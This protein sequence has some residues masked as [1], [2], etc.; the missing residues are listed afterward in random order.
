VIV[1]DIAKLNS[2]GYSGFPAISANSVATNDAFVDQWNDAL[3]RLVA[4]FDTMVQVAYCDDA[5]NK[6]AALLW[7]VDGVH[8]NEFGSAHIAEAIA[9]A[10]RRL[11]PPPGPRFATSAYVNSPSPRGGQVIR[12][13]RPATWYTAEYSQIGTAYTFVAGDVFAMPF[14]VTNP[15][16]R[17]RQFSMEITTAS[18]TTAATIRWGLYDDPGASGY[19]FGLMHELTSGGT[20][21]V[22]TTTG[23]KT[24]PLPAAA[25]S[26]DK[27]LDPGVYWLCFKV[28]TIGSAT[29]ACRTLGGK[30]LLMPNAQQ[31]GLPL[32]TTGGY[33]GYKLTGQ[34]TGVLSSQFPTGGALTDNVPFIGFLT[35]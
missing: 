26:I 6:N 18:A 1:C 12:T 23:V 35:T 25:G 13:H 14:Q 10:A 34:G 9:D 33:M 30:N 17:I 7:S 15:R 19:P 22:G 32:T 31:T 5:I 2:L 16:L 8:P 28:V 29:A 21:S 24:S 4:E 11:E 20:F 27:P 3:Y